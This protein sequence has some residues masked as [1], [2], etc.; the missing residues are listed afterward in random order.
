MRNRIIQ[1]MTHGEGSK[2]KATDNGEPVEDW[3][4]IVLAGKKVRQQQQQQQQSP[5]GA[6]SVMEES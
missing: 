4:R 3:D 5:S 6:M 1:K 2:K